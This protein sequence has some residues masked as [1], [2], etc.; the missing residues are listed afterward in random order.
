MRTWLILGFVKKFQL[1]FCQTAAIFA[2]ARFAKTQFF[3]RHPVA[4]DGCFK[5][6]VIVIVFVFVFVCVFVIV[7]VIADVKHLSNDA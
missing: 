4:Y 6:F 7:I 5:H 1:D 3:L 2:T